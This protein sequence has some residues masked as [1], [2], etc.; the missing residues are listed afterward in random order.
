MNFWEFSNATFIFFIFH[1]FWMNLLLDFTFSHLLYNSIIG[2]YIFTSFE[3]FNF[4]I[5]HFS[6]LSFLPWNPCAGHGTVESLTQPTPRSHTTLNPV[7]ITTRWTTI[8]QYCLTLN[9]GAPP[10]LLPTILWF[11]CTIATAIRHAMVKFQGHLAQ[12]IWGGLC[13]ITYGQ[14][15]YFLFMPGKLDYVT[16]THQMKHIIRVT[17]DICML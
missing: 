17:R 15:I 7:G 13:M 4:W 8:A 2:F 10:I 9:H 14:P 1:I 16:P 11:Q 3:F 12:N 6:L 5:L